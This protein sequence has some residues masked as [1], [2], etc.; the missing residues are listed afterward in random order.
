M[1]ETREV[2]VEFYPSTWS[3]RCGS[4]FSYSPQPFFAQNH[5]GS[6]LRA[7]RAEKRFVRSPDHVDGMLFV[8]D[9]VAQTQKG[10]ES[11]TRSLQELIWDVGSQN[12]GIASA[13][14][15]NWSKAPI[16]LYCCCEKDVNHFQQRLKDLVD[17]PSWVPQVMVLVQVT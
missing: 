2:F 3:F 8:L 6:D 1:R 15:P 11:S 16:P 10:S 4:P 17:Y 13:G 7:T 12:E 5:G 14:E 9:V